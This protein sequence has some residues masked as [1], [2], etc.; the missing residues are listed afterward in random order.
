MDALNNRIIINS[1]ILGEAKIDTWNKIKRRNSY[2]MHVFKV[3][4]YKRPTSK[5]T[6]RIVSCLNSRVD[7]E[8]YLIKITYKLQILQQFMVSN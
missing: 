4:P 7:N 3:L 5:H 6:E 1:I 8:Q 2:I